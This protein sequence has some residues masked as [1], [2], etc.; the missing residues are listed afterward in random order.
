MAKAENVLALA[1][2]LFVGS[3]NRAF[4]NYFAGRGVARDTLDTF[5]IG[6]VPARP[7]LACLPLRAHAFLAV[8]LLDRR[9]YQATGALRAR[10]TQSYSFPYVEGGDVLGMVF[11]SA[12]GELEESFRYCN[13]ERQDEV[14]VA[15]GRVVSPTFYGEDGAMAADHITVVEG[16]VDMLRAWQ[17]GIPNPV[18]LCGLGVGDDRVLD[19]LREPRTVTLFLD[20]DAEG[21]RRTFGLALRFLRYQREQERA[22][23]S[24]P[25]ARFPGHLQVVSPQDGLTWDDPGAAPS[26]DALIEIYDRRRFSFH[27]H[28]D[29]MLKKSLDLAEPWHRRIAKRFKEHG[30][31]LGRPL[32][33]PVRPRR[34]AGRTRGRTTRR[35]P[36]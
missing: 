14:P 26:D 12:G 27:E 18:A 25:C 11:R 32:N 21:R 6:Y 19:L 33:D 17:A 34:K 15:P 5:Q 23:E 31:Y 28:V 35:L 8:R 3:R 1:A 10:H 36:Q 30:G 4:W 9:Y 16:P 2:R 7:L 29:R 13:L 20:W 24:D 22:G